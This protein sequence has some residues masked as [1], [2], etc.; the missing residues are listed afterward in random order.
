MDDDNASTSGD[1]LEEQ[2]AGEVG[3][4]SCV[5]CGIDD[6]DDMSLICDGCDAVYHIWCLDPPLSEVPS[7]DW[8]CERCVR[9][10]LGMFNV[11]S[12]R[13]RVITN[14]SS[15][16]SEPSS[17]AFDSNSS[18][19]R[20]RYRIP[21]RLVDDD[22]GTSGTETL[23]NNHRQPVSMTEVYSRYFPRG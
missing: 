8:Y 10:R 15:M 14:R 17:G 1:H 13:G 20:F 11:T 16:Y 4:G 21:R 23:R 2:V 18:L 5:N 3:L 12:E 6:F 7:G 9:A 19:D 22:G